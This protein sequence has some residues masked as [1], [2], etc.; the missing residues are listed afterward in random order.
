VYDIVDL[1]AS[2]VAYDVNN[3]RQLVGYTSAGGNPQARLWT[4]APDGTVTTYNLQTDINAVASLGARSRFYPWAINDAGQVAGYASDGAST[5]DRAFYGTPSGGA[6]AFTDLQS[7]FPANDFRRAHDVN[8]AG[9][10]AGYFDQPSGPYD[11]WPQAVVVDTS[12]AGLPHTELDQG[13]HPHTTAYAISETGHIVGYCEQNPRYIAASWASDGLPLVELQPG[14]VPPPNPTPSSWAYG[15]NDVGLVVGRSRGTSLS[16]QPSD[17]FATLWDTTA[18]GAPVN[19]D[20]TDV[21]EQSFAFDIN[22]AL[23][24]VGYGDLTPYNTDP[25]EYHAF[26][27]TQDGGMVDL[28]TLVDPNSGWT[29]QIARSVNED[30]WIAGWG[31]LDG[32]PHGFVL[33]PVTHEVVIPEPATLSLLGL[34]LLAVARRRRR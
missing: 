32:E 16:S 10:V 8:N 14:S 30:G 5:T 33:R 29:L 24:A 6:Y 28:N 15:V 11:P 21:F 1:G 27:W 23:E 12:V 13:S 17:F 9:L 26:L 18:G 2:S 20:P 31:L 3:V 19:L 25:R 22:N 4:V 34:G 7:A